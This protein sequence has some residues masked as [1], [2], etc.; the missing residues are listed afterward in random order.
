[1]WEQVVIFIIVILAALYVIRSLRRAAS[2]QTACQQDYCTG[3]PYAGGCDR[4]Q[5][6]PS[7]PQQNVDET[8]PRT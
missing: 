3:C 7:L 6:E 8:E 4:R 2:G 5:D 1:M